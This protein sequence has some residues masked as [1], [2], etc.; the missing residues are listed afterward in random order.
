MDTSE[1]RALLKSAIIRTEKRIK[2]YRDLSG[3][4][5]PDNA[6]GRVSRMDAINNRGVMEAALRKAEEQL[7]GLER[8]FSLL[9]TEDFGKCAK[10][11][12]QIP[13]ER[14]LL[15]PESS[16]CVNCAR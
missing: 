6:I 8:N 10:C 2:Q 12:E 9:D 14:I 11:T 16:F 3:P 13:I 4:V 1:L 5:A 15:A 7:K